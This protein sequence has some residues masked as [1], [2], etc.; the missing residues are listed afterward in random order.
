[1]FLFLLIVGCQPDEEIERKGHFRLS[2]NPPTSANG[3]VENAAPSSILVTISNDAGELVIDQESYALIEVNGSY[4][5]PNIELIVGTYQVEEFLVLDDT[6][7]AI[8]LTPLA[9]S[10]LAVEVET[11]LPY[12]F[13]V[14]DDQVESVTLDVLSVDYGGPLDFGYATF[15][16]NVVDPIE[17]SLVAWYPFNGDATDVVGGNNGELHGGVLFSEDEDGVA[18]GALLLD[19]VDDFVLL[20]KTE[21]L[22]FGADD[23]TVA[24]KIRSSTLLEGIIFNTRNTSSCSQASGATVGMSITSDGVLRGGGRNA[25]NDR[26]LLFSESQVNNDNWHL[27]S[28]RRNGNELSISIGHEVHTTS[29][30]D[31]IDYSTVLDF[32]IGKTIYCTGAHLEGRIDDF[33]VF[34]RFLTISELESTYQ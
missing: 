10:P 24:M 34:D 25:A 18:N 28:M 27:V 14:L 2:Y 7:S 9:G 20:N 4:L 26:V 17:N 5:T 30:T 1:M 32:Y 21:A 8:Y 13:G 3:K 12:E 31:G 16:F 22:E 29:I 15:S 11:P 19:G 6:Q 33:K 23:F